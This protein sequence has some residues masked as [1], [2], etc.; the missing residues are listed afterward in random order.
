MK[1]TFYDVLK[2]ILLKQNGKLDEEPGF[3]QVFSTF[4]LVRYLSMKPTLMKYANQLNKWQGMLSNKYVYKY[5]YKHIP[6]QSSGF[7]QYI[8]KKK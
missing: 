2:D 4:M 7:I 6:K 1:I 8:K 5:A 3:E